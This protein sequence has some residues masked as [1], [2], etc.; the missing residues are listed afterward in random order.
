MKEQE[1]SKGKN[2][3]FRISVFIA[4]IIVL[5]FMAFRMSSLFSETQETIV[6]AVSVEIENAE[7]RDLIVS[8][9]ISAKVKPNDEV[10]IVPTMLGKVTNLYV[11]QGDKVSKGQLLFTVDQSQIVSSLNQ[12]REAE[13][14]AKSTFDR[15]SLLYE[16]GAVAFQDYEQARL[17]FVNAQQ[18]YLQVKTSYDNTEIKAPISGYITLSN[19]TVGTLPPQQGPSMVIADTDKL[20]VETEISEHIAGILEE[21]DMVE[22][23]VEAAGPEA[24]KGVVKFISQAPTFGKMTYNVQI[25][26][27]E[28]NKVKAGMFAKV[29]IV[30]SKKAKAV[31]VPSQSVIIKDGEKKIAV[32]ENDLPRFVKV[33]TG[34]DNGEYVEIL[35]GIKEGDK[36]I[37]KGQQYVVEGEAVKV[38]KE[39]T[40]ENE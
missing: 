20:L 8:T 32:L 29:K 40:K 37:V 9:P 35:S 16:Q 23:F 4:L 18:A 24:Q 21:G 2:K 12:A 36:V 7:L 39:G 17:S 14:V 11:K 13:N 10:T 6:S 15:L 1:N 22:V 38:I 34:L 3:G 25:E 27:L 5:G 33:E 30:N 28:K 31:S 26:L 19:V